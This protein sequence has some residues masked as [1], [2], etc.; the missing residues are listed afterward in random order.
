MLVF[1]LGVLLF[2]ETTVLACPACVVSDAKKD[3]GQSF[4]VLSAM[5]ILPIVAAVIVGF[6]IMKIGKNEHIKITDR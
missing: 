5:G 4:W 2:L 6:F 3:A 1:V